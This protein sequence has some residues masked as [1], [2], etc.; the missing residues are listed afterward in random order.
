M[1]WKQVIVTAGLALMGLSFYQCGGSAGGDT[2]TTPAPMSN[3]KAAADDG[4]GYYQLYCTSC[5]GP[6]GDMGFS[7]AADLK[8]SELP[9][10]EVISVIKNGKGLMTGF[11]NIMTEEQIQQVA[12]Y[13]MSLREG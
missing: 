13:T 10:E 11:K 7:G 8:S 12:D 6:N 4:K 3:S 5:H 9:K 1:Q 2:A